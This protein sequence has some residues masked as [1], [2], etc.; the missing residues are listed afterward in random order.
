MVNHCL[1]DSHLHLQDARFEGIRAEVLLRA[2]NAGVS[3]MLCNATREGDWPDVLHFSAT[4]PS[5]IPFIGI[6]PWYA[7]SVET[8]WDKRLAAVV[9]TNR[10]GI[11]EAGLDGK[12][13]IP[14]ASQETVLAVQL[15]L[16][17]E[18]QRPA[19]LHCVG[20]WGRLLDM[21][22]RL[23]KTGGLPPLMIHSFGGSLETM[24]RLVRL[25]CW[26]S[27]S[28]RLI[29][30]ERHMLQQVFCATPLDRILLE[31]DAPDQLSATLKNSATAYCNEPANIADLYRQAAQLR[32]MNLDDFTQQIWNNGEIYADSLLPR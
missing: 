20:A 12:C 30:C 25:G 17:R 9:A 22:A 11:G 10:C 29:N 15:E 23:A 26:I 2:A 3:R 31:T 16:A 6:H 32:H 18:Y 19:A 24:H 7:A 4:C 27:F 8:G 13:R 21:L 5:V 1:L 28:A 14:V